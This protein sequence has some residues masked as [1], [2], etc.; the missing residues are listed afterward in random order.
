MYMKQ[1]ET[2]RKKPISKGS[3]NRKLAEQIFK[4]TQ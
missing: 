3:Q 1:Q 2:Q 4:I